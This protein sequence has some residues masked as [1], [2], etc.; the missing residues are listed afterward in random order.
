MYVSRFIQALIVVGTVAAVAFIASAVELAASG[1][2]RAQDVARDLKCFDNAAFETG[3][4]IFTPCAANPRDMT[5]ASVGL[6]VTNPGG[7]SA[8]VDMHRCTVTQA[9]RLQDHVLAFA[10]FREVNEG[11]SGERS[12]VR[13]GQGSGVVKPEED[14]YQAIQALSGDQSSQ[15]WEPLPYAGGGIEVN[16]PNM[17]IT[18]AAAYS[19]GEC[20][21][22]DAEWVKCTYHGCIE[23][24]SRRQRGYSC[25]SEP[26]GSAS[27]AVYETWV[28]KVSVRVTDFCRGRWRVSYGRGQDHRE[29]YVSSRKP[30]EGRSCGGPMTNVRADLL[31][32]N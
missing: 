2:A 24:E 21:T 8:R 3:G 5:A 9:L 18:F 30:A 27:E 6:R 7:R 1:G 29:V 19:G 32:G 26:Q 25:I 23:V 22:P 28:N 14:F 31:G 4:L 17:T 13:W 12:G 15:R 20:V 10:R 16:C 11:V